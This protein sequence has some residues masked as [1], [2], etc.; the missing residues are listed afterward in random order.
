MF[1]QELHNFIRSAGNRAPSFRRAAYLLGYNCG[2]VIR[3]LGSEVFLSENDQPST[4]GIGRKR[5]P[6]Q[7]VETQDT[8]IN[9]L[10]TDVLSQEAKFPPLVRP[11]RLLFFC[12][13]ASIPDI[14]QSRKVGGFPG[15]IHEMSLAPVCDSDHIRLEVQDR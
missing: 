1:R 14:I 9:K 5:E 12:E 7:A 2:K 8:D 13:F 10:P 6:Y 15:G 3:I 4:Q 11:I